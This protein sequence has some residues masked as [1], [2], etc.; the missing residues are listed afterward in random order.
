MKQHGFTLIEMMVVIV[1][2]GILA[3]MALPSFTIFI[4]N[5]KTRTASEQLR[6][7][8]ILARQEAIKRNAPVDIAAK[9]NLITASIA[10]FGNSPAIELARFYSKAQV[11]DASVTMGGNGRATAAKTFSVS[12]TSKQCK[13]NGGPISCLNV[14]VLLGG[15]VRLCD[16]TK[17]AGDA[18][19]CL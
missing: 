11:G 10:A 1:I 5:R 9:G 3:A 14:Q 15:A 16:A 6:D 8:A 2:T 18:S 13:A 19:A 12:S 7:I 4:E 17:A